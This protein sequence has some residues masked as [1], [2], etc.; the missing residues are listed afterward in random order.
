[1]HRDIICSQMS[2][3]EIIKEL[4][5][6]VR[7]QE[8]EYEFSSDF[9]EWFYYNLYRDQGFIEYP[10]LKQVQLEPE[11]EMMKH[12]CYY[13]INVSYAKHFTDETR[14]KLYEDM[15]RWTICTVQ[16]H[17]DLLNSSDF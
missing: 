16:K 3:I 13:L 6:Q 17:E 1:M 8:E 5:T 10:V 12:L 2:L 4:S 7:A 14:I 11:Y 15:K 9:L